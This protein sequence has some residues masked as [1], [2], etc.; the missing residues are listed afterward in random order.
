VAADPLVFIVSGPGGVGKGT[1]VDALV[2]RDRTL[3]LS[4]SWT[5]RD[6]RRGEPDGAYVWVTRTEFETPDRGRRVPRMDDF[7]GNY[8]GTP[9]PSR[10]PATTRFSRSRWTARA[11]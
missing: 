10:R 5:T 9:N 2:R 1:I 4:R 8:Y 7:L 6:R 3:W 11:R